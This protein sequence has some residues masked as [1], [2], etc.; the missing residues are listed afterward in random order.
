MKIFWRLEDNFRNTE[1][2]LHETH[3]HF[4]LCI[5]DILLRYGYTIVNKHWITRS[6][7][8]KKVLQK[9]IFSSFKKYKLYYLRVIT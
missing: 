2:C 5:F 6:L 1:N 9:K 3:F 7:H 8:S 4:V